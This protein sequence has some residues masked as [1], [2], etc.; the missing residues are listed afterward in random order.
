[1]QRP[2]EVE[3][4]VYLM[5]DVIQSEDSGVLERKNGFSGGSEGE[6]GELS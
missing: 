1:M 3:Q 5:V 6:S 4:D 2:L